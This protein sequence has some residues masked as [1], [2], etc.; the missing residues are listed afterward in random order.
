[1]TIKQSLESYVKV[2]KDYTKSKQQLINDIKLWF[3]KHHV[4]VKELVSCE[5]EE[6]MLKLKF[7][8]TKEYALMVNVMI[9]EY[10]FYIL[11]LYTETVAIDYQ[12]LKLSDTY[13]TLR[14]MYD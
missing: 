8:G 11:Q 7:N 2:C 3:K 14:I 13:V 12:G 10:N 5:L 4:S 9:D 1:M 6:D